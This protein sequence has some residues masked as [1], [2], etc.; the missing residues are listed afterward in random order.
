M[1][2]SLWLFLILAFS[3]GMS[4]ALAIR[5]YYFEAT[6]TVAQAAEPTT[7]IL[8]AKR[9]I[10]GGMEITAEF[11]VFQDVPLSEVPSGSLTSFAQVYRR[12]PVGSI[13]AGYPI[14]EDLLLPQATALQ[15]TAFV[16]TGSQ[17]VTLDVVHIR[18]GDQ[19]FSPTEPLSTLL[20]ADQRIDIRVVPPEV[21]GRLAEK[22]QELLRTFGTQDIRNSGELILENVPIHRIQRQF[23]AGETGVARD[24]LELML[25]KNEA[26]RLTAAA[27]RGQVRIFICPDTVP[28]PQRAEV[29][30]IVAETFAAIAPHPIAAP[31]IANPQTPSPDVVP[32]NTQPNS[33]PLAQL[34]PQD[35][36]QHVSAPTAVPVEPVQRIAPAPPDIFPLVS[37]P[38]T[39]ITPLPMMRTE[40]LSQNADR[41]TELSGDE[42]DA[43]R[44]DGIVAF[45]HSEGIIAFGTLPMRTIASTSLEDVASVPPITE[46]PLPTHI[47]HQEAFVPLQP[48]H[49]HSELAIGSPRVTNA[50]QFL[51]PGNLP[52]GNMAPVRDYPQ[53]TMW[54]TETTVSQL[55]MPAVMPSII[56]VPQGAPERSLE[57]TPFERRIYTVRPEANFGSSPND[58]LLA[59]QR[60][61]R[62]S[63][64]VT[65][66]Q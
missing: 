16:P 26:D 20:S 23:V 18:Q 1:R 9:T 36:P 43:I 10:P 38:P 52:P 40:E 57:Y 33:P 13:P 44:N 41:Q 8:F 54:Q 24:A 12:Q 62:S 34:W 4:C 56:P 3:A 17:L 47:P 48:S 15:Q 64:S 19:V 50:I 7:K 5:F 65:Q 60:L 25:D 21:Q 6:P 2:L 31:P 55:V 32:A 29:G 22:K 11:V 27:R 63:D 51:P 53:A 66:A 14:C 28:Q 37:S 45:D 42:M 61:P 59:P 58:E 46:F 39:T 30:T 49:D 35:I